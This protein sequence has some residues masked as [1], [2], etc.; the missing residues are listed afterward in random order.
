MGCVDGGAA[1]TPVVA[2]VPIALLAMPS[3]PALAH[4]IVEEV[5]PADG[6]LLASA[7][8]E[9]RVRFSEPISDRFVEVS[10]LTSSTAIDEVLVG[11]LDGSDPRVLVVALPPLADGLYQVG[12]PVHDGILHEVRGRTSFSIGDH[13]DCPR[14]AHRPLPHRN[15][16]R[17]PHVGRSPSDWRCWS[18]SC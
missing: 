8:S 16:S 1:H 12:F 13:H 11:T 4:A 10:F 14:P 9:L 6:T 18:V 5:S 15:R 2:F 7:P 17:P 3:G